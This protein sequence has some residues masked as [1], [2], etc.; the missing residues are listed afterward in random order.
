VT[1]IDV[2]CPVCAAQPNERCV[3]PIASIGDLEH[4]MFLPNAHAERLEAVS[5]VESLAQ[6][7]ADRAPITDAE[8]LATGEV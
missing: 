8:I 7:A 2:A 3:D 1:W 6:P 5:F 4:P